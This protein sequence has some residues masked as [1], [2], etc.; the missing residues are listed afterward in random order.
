MI[1]MATSTFDK[2]IV[3]NE[4]AADVIIDS[5]KNPTVVDDSKVRKVLDEL[6]RSKT[7]LVKLSLR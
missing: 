4:K 2:K 6:E 3:I 7:K 5:F 1:N